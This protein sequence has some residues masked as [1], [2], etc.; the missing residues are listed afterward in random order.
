MP[1]LESLHH[2][3]V[4]IVSN[5]S[6]LPEVVGKAGMI[7]DPFSETQIMRGMDKAISMNK[8]QVKAFQSAAKKQVDEFSWKKSAEKLLRIFESILTTN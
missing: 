1:A 3:V 6:S 2:R 4:P 8:K 7:V 5:I